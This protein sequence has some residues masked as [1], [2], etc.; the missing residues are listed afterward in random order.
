[1]SGRKFKLD[2]PAPKRRHT[3][4]DKYVIYVLWLIGHSERSISFV[5]GFRLKQIAGIIGKSDYSNRSAMTDQERR[6][7][8]QELRDVRFEDGVPLDGGKLDRIAWDLLPLGKRQLR[9]PLKRK[10]K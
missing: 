3:D 9:G 4:P 2:I 1:M 8:L 6:N 7:L 10:M 5:M